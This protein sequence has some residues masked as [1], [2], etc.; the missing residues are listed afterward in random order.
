[1]EGAS[2]TETTDARGALGITVNKPH[3]VALQN[4]LNYY[5]KLSEHYAYTSSYGDK[6]YQDLGLISIP[7]IFS[8]SSIKR[9]SVELKFYLSGTLMAKCEDKDRNRFPSI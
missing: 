6:S 1:M 5:R 4:T 8:G 2:T 7:S 9:G 3:L